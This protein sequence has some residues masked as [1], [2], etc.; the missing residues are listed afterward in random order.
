M[1]WTL[2]S[3]AWWMLPARRRGIETNLS[4]IAADRSPRERRR[5]S[6][7]TFRNFAYV[8]V[9]FLRLPW[10]MRE[11]VLEL[12]DV[13]G[14][15]LFDEAVDAGRGL[16][17]VS[18]HLGAIDMA[19]VYAAAAGYP[20][21]GLVEDIDPALLDVV[22]RY[23][24]STGMEIVTVRGGLRPALAAL[25]RGGVVVTGGDRAIA[26]AGLTVDFCGGRRPFPLGPAALALRAGAPIGVA[27]LVAQATGPRPYRLVVH[28]V[29][30]PVGTAESLTRQIADD[31]S[32]VVLAY[33]DHWFVFRSDWTTLD[34]PAVERPRDTARNRLDWSV[35]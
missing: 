14:R 13:A 12:A 1:A 3:A 16:V 6:R 21:T 25:R 31:M 27:Y 2:A 24:A 34:D 26:E 28:S 18:P 17:L 20:V 29:R 10:L 8:W 4:F 23:R 11:D 19:G 5:L 30:P 32:A 7:A 22:R 33:P 35:S 9:D 15:A